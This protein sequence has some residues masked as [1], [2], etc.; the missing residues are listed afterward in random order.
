[1]QNY[2]KDIAAYI[3]RFFR[4]TQVMLC[5]AAR[6]SGAIASTAL[7]LRPCQRARGGARGLYADGRA[8][9]SSDKCTARP[10]SA[11]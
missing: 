4:D 9:D 7:S 10:T 5:S 8:S 1:M 2:T 3:K 11:A 6:G